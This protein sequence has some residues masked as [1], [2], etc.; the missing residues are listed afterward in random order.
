MHPKVWETRGGTKQ[1][2]LVMRSLERHTSGHFKQP[3][4]RTGVSKLF[5]VN[6]RSAPVR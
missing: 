3:N 6:E 2:I 1:N 5:I 4:V